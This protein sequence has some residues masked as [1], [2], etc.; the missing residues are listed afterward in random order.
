[1][2]KIIGLLFLFCVSSVSYAAPIKNVIGKIDKVQVMGMNYFSYS[3]E[4]QAIAFI[5]M[6]NLP[7][8]CDNTGGFKRVAITS[9]H[10]AFDA[11][12]SM[13]MAAKAADRDVH[14]H[15]LE[16]CTLWNNNAWDFTI[17]HML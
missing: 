7:P 3:S 15:Y 4:G 13:A 11:V 5:H 16:E 6:E 9:D 14:I 17:L 2:K 8:A 1:M 10:P 12:V